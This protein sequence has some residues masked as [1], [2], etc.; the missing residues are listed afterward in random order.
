MTV[1]E[2]QEFCARVQNQ[3]PAIVAMQEALAR[4]M[5]QRDFLAE[6]LMM[7]GDTDAQA[8]YDKFLEMKRKTG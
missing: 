5:K 3:S 8:V 4:I 2:L 1:D 6:Y 7:C